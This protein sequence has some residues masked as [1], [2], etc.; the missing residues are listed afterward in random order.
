MSFRSILD[1]EV[2]VRLLRNMLRRGRVP[3]G[4]L[5]WGPG[6]VGKR[7]A[8]GEMAKAVNCLK[9]GD[10]ACDECLS[11]RKVKSGNH[12]DVRV[13]AP[14]GKSRII[15]VGAVEL[16]NEFASLRSFESK[17]RVFII[18]E[19][20]RMGVPAQNHFLKTLEEPPGNSVFILISEF[21]GLLLPTIRS[22]CQRIRFGTLR[23]ETI[24]ELL[25]RERD[26]PDDVAEAIAGIAQGQMS[27]AVDLVDSD[28]REIATEITRRLAA[29]DDPLA[30]AGEFAKH[31][32]ARRKQI[33]AAIKSELDEADWA[34]DDLSR[35]G[36]E[37]LMTQQ[38]AVAEA[39][40]RTDIM[41]YL[42]LLE[43]WYR[44]RLV[45]SVTGEAALVLNRDQIDQLSP[46][47]APDFDKKFA[48]LEKAREYLERFLKE[49]RV[50]RDL[51]FALA[52]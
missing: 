2:P 10:D 34:R 27:R 44:D 11:C 4:L 32:D 38:L 40:I 29:G 50:F 43:M 42:R 20:D 7:L 9:G 3:N 30:V 22:R 23:P 18:H 47:Q 17:W 16:M 33:E 24:K 52:D 12:P 19:A 14:V 31:L 46:A 21:P 37:E 41:E 26:L 6:G 13:L 1:Q 15:N 25:L 39:T 36:R 51:F 45:Y 48:A 49:E 8:A 28:K 5:F 35:D